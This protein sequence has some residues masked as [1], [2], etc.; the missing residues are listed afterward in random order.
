MRTLPASIIL[1]ATLPFFINANDK[2]AQADTFIAQVEIEK[3]GGRITGFSLPLLP[4][5]GMESS[6]VIAFN[7]H[8]KPTHGVSA[9]HKTDGQSSSASIWL[10]DD[11]RAFV[12]VNSVECG[13]QQLLSAV[14]RDMKSSFSMRNGECAVNVSLDKLT[15]GT[16]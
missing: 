5:Q 4:N 3:S 6:T 1:L 14:S 7:Q 12:V 8:L 16:H 10:T 11:S 9:E 15:A 2:V 13:T